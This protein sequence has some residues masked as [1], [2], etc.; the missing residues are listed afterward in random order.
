MRTVRLALVLALLGPAVRSQDVVWERVG[1]ANEH[2]LRGHIAVL[3][4]LNGDRHHDLLAIV[5][6]WDRPAG[7]WQDTE[8]WFF[9]GKDGSTL[10]KRGMF[11]PGRPYEEIAAAGDA[12]GDGVPDYAA[13]VRDPFTG[14]LP[15]I[16]VR[17]GK[18]DALIWSISG[19]PGVYGLGALLGDAD[20]DG[21]GRPDLA[22][23]APQDGPYGAVYVYRHGGTQLYRLPGT[24]ALQFRF[25]GS[26]VLG[27]LGDFDGDGAD[28]YVVGAL[29]GVTGL[30]AA[31]VLSGPTGQVLVKALGPPNENLGS[32]VDGAGD[33]DGDGVLDFVASSSGT[34]NVGA[35][36]AFS[37]RTGQPIHTWRG[38]RGGSGFG[39]SIAGD[40]DLDQDGVPDV[41]VGAPDLYLPATNTEGSVFAFSGRDGALL[42]R[43]DFQGPFSKSGLGYWLDVVPPSPASPFAMLALTEPSYGPYNSTIGIGVIERGRIRLFHGSPSGVEVY[44][45]S[46]SGTLPS[47]PRVGMRDE[48]GRAARVH[49][50]GAPSG[51]QA[52][53]LLGLSRQTFLGQPLPLSLAGYGLPGC[54]LFTSI[55]AFIPVTAGT[56]GIGAGYGFVDIPLTLVPPAQATLT[57]RGQWLVLPQH[58][59]GGALSAPIQWQH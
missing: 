17:S 39:T 57:L 25:Q 8:L 35:A 28:D 29:D 46:C 48:Q 1:V 3:G 52:F 19:P 45:P 6:V 23:T 18:D 53:L 38:T 34:F 32:A 47:P 14:Q 27:R 55:E 16:E 33:M 5:R 10:R 24:V 22:V 36:V 37:G 31:A 21:D 20:F 41:V 2:N 7:K 44:G 56:G 58:G 9:S 40:V 49:L 50:S 26:G 12:D 13:T 51:T 42:H 11:A 15:L 43:I 54:D 4:D 30:G 59:V